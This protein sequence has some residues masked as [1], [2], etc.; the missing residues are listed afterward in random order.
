MPIY[1]AFNKRSGAWVKYELGK[2]GFKPLDVKQKNPRTPF[3]NV[4]KKG[5]RI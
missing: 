2:N 5:K 4:E 1:Q 3:K